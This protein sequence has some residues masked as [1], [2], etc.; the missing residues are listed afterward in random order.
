MDVHLLG[1]TSQLFEVGN[2]GFRLREDGALAVVSRQRPEPMA[3][4]GSALAVRSVWPMCFQPE[5][6]HAEACGDIRV[7]NRREERL[8]LA[9]Q[10]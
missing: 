3:G 8:R 1:P 6:S 5:L 4:L 2:L 10:T 9:Q 7:P